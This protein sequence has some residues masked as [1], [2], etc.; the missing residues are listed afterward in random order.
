MRTRV[1]RAGTR[2]AGIRPEP[3]IAPGEPADLVTLLMTCV[4]VPEYRARAGGPPGA[5]VEVG[6]T[7]P[8]GE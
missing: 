4:G 8:R 3:R 6:L 2:S 1:R 5:P 7:R